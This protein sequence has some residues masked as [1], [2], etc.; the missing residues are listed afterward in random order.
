MR[1]CQN[2]ANEW[3]KDWIVEKDTKN[4]LEA[5]VLNLTLDDTKQYQPG[6]NFI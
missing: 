2:E 5:P 4:W 3:K 1:Y 6:S